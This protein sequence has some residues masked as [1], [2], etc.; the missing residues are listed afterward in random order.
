MTNMEL[1]RRS[2]IVTAAAA[3]GGL[4]LGVGSASAAVVNATPWMAPTDKDGTE[5]SHWVS[6]DPEGVVTMRQAQQEMG[7]GTFTGNPQMLAEEMHVDWNMVRVQYVDVNRHVN[8]DN[9]YGRMSTV[10][11]GGTRRSRVALQQAGASVRERMKAAAAAAWGVNPS[12]VAAKDSVLSSGNNTGTFA[13]FATA[14]AQ[15]ALAEEPEIKTPDQFTLIGTSVARLDTP[16]KVNGSA[17]HA[18]D[19]RVP[20]MVYAVVLSNPVTWQ[21]LKSYDFSA[22]ADRPGVIAAVE[23]T[24]DPE[25]MDFRQGRRN[26]RPGVAVVADTWYRAKTAADLMPIEWDPGT[27]GNVSTDS[28]YAAMYDVINLPG[29]ATESRG[30]TRGTT[31]MELAAHTGINYLDAEPTGDALGIIGASSNVMTADYHRPYQAHAR[32]E[33]S[34]A[35]VS[36][37]QSRVDAWLSSQNPPGEVGMIADIT[38]LDPTDIYVHNHFL[39]GGYGGSGPAGMGAMTATYIANEIGLPVQ[40]HWTREGDLQQNAHRPAN[41]T[42]FQAVI[43][44]DGLPLANFT[45]SVNPT[46]EH[47]R[48][49][50]RISD[51]PYLIPNRHHEIA[52]TDA[53]NIIGT[54]H[55]APGSGQNGFMIEQ[56]VDE[57]ALAGGWDPLDW[58]I[59]LTQHR[60]DMQLV[61][62]TLKNT[63]AFMTDLPRG[64]GTGIGMV[65]SHGSIVALVSHITVSRRGQ[66]RV[67]KMTMAYDPG[68]VVNP[69]MCEAQLEGCVAWEMSHVITGELIIKGGRITTDNFDTYMLTR[70][71]D[72]P[73]IEIHAALSGGDKWGGMG[74]PGAPPVGGAIGNA[75]FFAT[76]KRVRSTPVISHDLSWS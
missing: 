30:S 18:I 52:L 3:G 19:A 49:G 43:G 9:L 69:K 17:Q 46:L 27:R 26:I 47:D 70:M 16:L 2:F 35:T 25:I 68:H 66:L 34:G 74:E 48:A 38:G 65:E 20:G 63:G 75:I 33:V 42:R 1:N 40:T 12:Q 39:G 7:Q 64:E 41:A 58:R 4:L 57:M 29:F 76:G 72:T 23:L 54:H 22:I 44:D 24:A 59:A 14:A 53:S 13:E 73:V 62:N 5:V 28:I 67:E 61:L 21:P 32:M 55:R 6:I 10:G 11:S 15:I 31:D 60:P 51:H 71:G 37:Q 45:R 56:F 8:N 50:D 36:V